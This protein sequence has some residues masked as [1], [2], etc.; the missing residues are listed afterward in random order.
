MPRVPRTPHAPTP[1]TPY[2]SVG[3]RPYAP[4]L[5]FYNHLVR[6]LRTQAVFHALPTLD[7]EAALHY[8]RTHGAGGVIVG[9]HLER[10]AMTLADDT[11]FSAVEAGAANAMLIAADGSTLAVNTVVSAVA[12]ALKRARVRP[13][14]SVLVHGAGAPASAVC[15]ALRLHGNQDV[16]ITGRNEHA[17]R[18]MAA[19]HG[20]RWA[21]M[22]PRDTHVLI[23]ATPLGD[24]GPLAQEF[25]LPA[26][27]VVDANAVIDLALGPHSTPVVRLAREADVRAI[28]GMA[29]VADQWVSIFRTFTGSRVRGGLVDRALR[30]AYAPASSR[31]GRSVPA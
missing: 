31:R 27:A 16:T 7:L 22:V 1:A 21:P 25:S 6:T 4:A 23:N 30:E 20:F 26:E 24:M 15:A 5:D 12:A 10:Q 2:F 19:L 14:D 9:K 11:D 29:I 13:S 17:G 28:P 8:A 18:L 3:A